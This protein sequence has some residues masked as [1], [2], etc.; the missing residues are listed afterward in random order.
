V[1]FFVRKRPIDGQS[2]L[3]PEGD[4]KAL[5]ED[6]ALHYEVTQ[7]QPTAAPLE[8][9]TT[10]G[11]LAPGV[12]EAGRK[13]AQHAAA[14]LPTPVPPHVP[15]PPPPAPPRNP[16]RPQEELD[17][18]AAYRQYLAMLINNPHPRLSPRHFTRHVN[19]CKEK[20]AAR[21]PQGAKAARGGGYG[22]VLL[23][24]VVAVLVVLLKGHR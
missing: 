13:E 4:L 8:R 9:P 22:W 6:W 11:G 3:L 2:V 20:A 21:F 15:A 14:T 5:E 12:D 7:R 24:C 18:E 10:L 16:P 17:T 23:L 1:P 19:R